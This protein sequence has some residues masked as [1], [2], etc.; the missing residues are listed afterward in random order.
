MLIRGS[1][2][3][4]IEFAFQVFDKE[5]KGYLEPDEYKFYVRSLIKASKMVKHNKEDPV[6][7]KELAQFETKLLGLAKKGDAEVKYG[8][9]H[10]ALLGDT[11]IQY[12]HNLTQP[13]EAEPVVSIIDEPEVPTEVEKKDIVVEKKE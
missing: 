8:D 10:N 13:K 4:K 3:E 9:I 5:E 1:L 2:D 6:F 11:F 12:C 7:D